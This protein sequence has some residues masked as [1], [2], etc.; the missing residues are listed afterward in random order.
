[1][2]G[3]ECTL[4]LTGAHAQVHMYTHTHTHTT[5]TPRTHGLVPSKRNTRK[6]WE[7][8]RTVSLAGRKPKR[9]LVVGHKA[10]SVGALVRLEA[11]I[12]FWARLSVQ[13]GQRKED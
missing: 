9:E 13:L 12:M 3:M 10:V 5:H 7:S 1:M 2:Q 6:R 4:E 8:A 11:A